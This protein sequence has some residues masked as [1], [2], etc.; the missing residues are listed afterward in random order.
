MKA[1]VLKKHGPAE[2]LKIS[3]IE[4]PEP[5]P[6]QVRVKVKTIGLNYAEILSRKGIYNW[7]PKRPYT[8]GMECYGVIDSVGEN[9][10]RKVGEKVIAGSQFGS[11]AEYIVV[12]EH[13]ALKAIPGFNE[14]EQAAVLVNFLTAYIALFELARIRPSDSV[15]ITSAAGGVG[16]AAIMFAKALGCKIAGASGGKDKIVRSVGADFSVDYRNENWKEKL[17][18]KFPTGFDV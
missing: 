13:L 4:K 17:G 6:G 16:S 7:S 10:K 11:Y 12:D 2:S 18:E 3:E 15:L 8:L 5:G 14:N 9:V 1:Y